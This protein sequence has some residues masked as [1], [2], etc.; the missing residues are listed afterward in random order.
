MP[1]GAFNK[2]EY[3]LKERH[4]P[5]R[6]FLLPIFVSNLEKLFF[7]VRPLSLPKTK[8]KL[9]LLLNT[10]NLLKHFI[11]N[12]WPIYL[13]VLYGFTIYEVLLLYCVQ[14]ASAISACVVTVILYFSIHLFQ[15]TSFLQQKLCKPTHEK[16]F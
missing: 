11:R 13:K 12:F 7:R 3:L 9:L 14:K 15:R 1:Y 16:Q 5:S 10:C 4:V 2:K 6:G 8:T